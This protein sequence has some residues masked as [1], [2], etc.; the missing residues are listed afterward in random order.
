MLE[1]SGKKRWKVLW[2]GTEGESEREREKTLDRIN[3]KGN[4][5]IN[6]DR[7]PP[8][9]KRVERPLFTSSFSFF[10]L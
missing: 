4:R 10:D 3:T 1:V 6:G 7:N 2:T 5:E 9:H 8:E